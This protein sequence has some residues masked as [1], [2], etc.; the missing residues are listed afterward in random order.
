MGS[1]FS[2][3]LSVFKSQF[4]K[5]AETLDYVV[6]GLSVKYK[7][8]QHFLVFLNSLPDNKILDRSKFTAFADNKIDVSQKFEFVLEMVENIV[9]KGENASYQ[10]FLLFHNVF[11]RH[12]IQGHLESGLCGK[13]LNVFNSLFLQAC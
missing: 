2:F 9:G 4:L 8:Y 12:L 1:I 3:S 11:K 7:F 10:Y 6:K 13:D 5:V